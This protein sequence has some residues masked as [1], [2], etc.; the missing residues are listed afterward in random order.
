MQLPGNRLMRIVVV[1]LTALHCALASPT[2]RVRRNGLAEVARTAR[3]CLPEIVTRL[4]GRPCPNAGLRRVRLHDLRH[5][6]ASLLLAAGVPLAVVSK[7]LGHSSISLA[8]DTYS[9]LQEGVG[10]EA[11]ERSRNLVPRAL[12]DHSVTSQASE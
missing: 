11:A 10:R 8:N 2:D 12:R 5:G 4:F 1:R 9:H 7:R 6:Q 3:R